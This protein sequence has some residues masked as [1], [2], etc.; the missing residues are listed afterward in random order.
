M[1]VLKISEPRAPMA[2]F[3]TGRYLTN[4]GNHFLVMKEISSTTTKIIA[5]AN[6]VFI[7]V[8][9]YVISC[10]QKAKKTPQ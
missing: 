7:V 4:P 2:V 1:S 3:I 10:V 8:V 5:I 9:L 6:P